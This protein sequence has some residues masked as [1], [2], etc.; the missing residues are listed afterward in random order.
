MKA[1][2]RSGSRGPLLGRQALDLLWATFW[3]AVCGRWRGIFL[4]FVFR[5][6]LPRQ[7][8][9]GVF[10]GYRFAGAMPVIRRF[11]IRPAAFFPQL[12]CALANALLAI[13]VVLV[14]YFLSPLSISLF[15]RGALLRL[16]RRWLP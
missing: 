2:H 5:K 10:A 11:T 12:V 7:F 1:G 14:F 15:A 9:L 8:Q 13:S 4:P 3:R 6:P 16:F